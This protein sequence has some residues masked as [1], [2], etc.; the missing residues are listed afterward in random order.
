M[1]KK[2]ILLIIF[3]LI[4]VPA[5]CGTYN[6]WD[7]HQN[8]NGAPH[9]TGWTYVAPYGTMPYEMNWVAYGAEAD[10]TY[11]RSMTFAEEATITHINIKLIEGQDNWSHAWLVVYDAGKDL[12]GYSDPLSNSNSSGWT[13]EIALNEVSGGSLTVSM[14]DTVYYGIQWDYSGTGIMGFSR[15]AIVTDAMENHSFLSSNAVGSSVLS[16]ISSWSTTT[17]E[18]FGIILHYTIDITNT[19]QTY[20]VTQSGASGHDGSS[21]NEWSMAE[22]NSSSKWSATE[23]AT[24]IDP[25]DTVNFSGSFTTALQIPTGY[26]GLQ[27]LPVYLDGWAGGDC[28]MLANRGC[29]AAATI[30]IAGTGSS[31]SCIEGVGSSYIQ[32]K[33]FVLADAGGGVWFTDDGTAPI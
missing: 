1:M 24:K 23:S 16:S 3:I 13:G 29:A 5:F 4:S 11:L 7:G 21:G 2:T 17:S 28:D 9:D 10:R 31:D 6:R 20:Y 32:V 15:N 8:Y 14:W 26:G 30:D 18:G 19:A 33:D 22:F 27:G 12:I 25:G